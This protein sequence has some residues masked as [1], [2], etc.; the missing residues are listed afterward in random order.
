MKTHLS[1]L[2]TSLLISG[3]FGY[4]PFQPPPYLSESWEKAGASETDVIASLLEC[5]FTQPTGRVSGLQHLLTPD[6][7][8]LATLCM[9]RSGFKAKYGN[10]YAN[11]CRNSKVISACQPGASSPMP[12]PA[13]RL[14]SQF[15]R[16]FPHS[17]ACS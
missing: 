1:L 8:A 7:A 12:N 9:E 5:G 4:K 15:C 17:G 2:L 3:C 6:E 14:N 13:K 11:F 10:S 16:S